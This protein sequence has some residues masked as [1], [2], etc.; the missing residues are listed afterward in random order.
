MRQD[1]GVYSAAELT[2]RGIDDLQRRKLCRAGR[3]VRLR[4]GWWA[5]PGA[6]EDIVSAVR[7]G[8]VLACVSALEKHGAWVP[9]TDSPHIRASARARRSGRP[10]GR[11]SVG[12]GGFP[13][14]VDPADVALACASRCLPGEQFV[15][16]CDSVLNLRILTSSEVVSAL[17]NESASVRRLLE[18]VDGSSQ[19]GTESLVRLR[20]RSARIGVRTQ[21][22]IPGVGRVDLLVGR[23]LIIEIDSRAHHTGVEHYATDRRRDRMSVAGGYLVLRVTYEDVMYG[24]KEVFADISALVHRREHQRRVVSVASAD[25]ADDY[26]RDDAQSR[27]I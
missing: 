9:R 21:V 25:R 7:T 10:V 18:R 4:H 15:A 19:S 14:A 13:S 3:L 11:C 27:S 24:W 5:V 16:V 22:T 20:L 23:R 17:A 26:C 8:G 1:W 2:R 12:R 6:D